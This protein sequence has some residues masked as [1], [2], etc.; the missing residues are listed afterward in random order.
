M[1]NQTKNIEIKGTSNLAE[2]VRQNLEKLV[3]AKMN[4]LNPEKGY[5]YLH[6]DG[7]LREGRNNEYGQ[8]SVSGF[9]GISSNRFT[10]IGELQRLIWMH[11]SQEFNGDKKIKEY[12]ND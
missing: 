11:E 6:I 12:L 3:N 1:E 10:A 5:I 8:S 9:G 4:I 7:E 2:Y